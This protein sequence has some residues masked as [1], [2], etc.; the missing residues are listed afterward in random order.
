MLREMGGAPPDPNAEPHHCCIH[1]PGPAVAKLSCHEESKVVPVA[2]HNC[3]H[4]PE[5][6]ATPPSEKSCC[7]SMA[8]IVE[9]VPVKESSC[10]DVTAEIVEKAP[11]KSSC[12][13]A[14]DAAQPAR[15][16]HHREN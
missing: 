4:E 3:C 5:V 2:A 9:A 7:S 6:V 15:T 16:S 13:S 11:V 10:C 8:E 1:E 14:S 12:C